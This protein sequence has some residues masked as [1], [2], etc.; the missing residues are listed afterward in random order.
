[1]SN[2]YCIRIKRI[3][4][5]E[6]SQLNSNTYIMIYLQIPI[7]KLPLSFNL[8]CLQNGQV[9]LPL[10]PIEN[11]SS[12]SPNDFLLPNNTSKCLNDTAGAYCGIICPLCNT[13]V[14]VNPLSVCVTPWTPYPAKFGISF[15]G[16][17]GILTSSLGL[18]WNPCFPF[19]K[20]LWI[21]K[22]VTLGWIT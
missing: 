14:H 16:T 20:R 12:A 3:K 18:V 13:V 17:S 11:P 9:K 10:I 21:L 6:S 15:V 5:S 1:M 7:S 8:L 4:S 2:G 19:Q 22:A